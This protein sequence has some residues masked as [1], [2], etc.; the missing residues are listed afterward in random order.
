MGKGRNTTVVGIRLP[1]ET[2]NRLKAV[3]RKN[4]LTMT[5]LLRPVIEDYAISG[6]GGNNV[7]K[8]LSI[9]NPS[10]RIPPVEESSAIPWDETEQFLGLGKSPDYRKSPA[11]KPEVKYRVD[12]SVALAHGL[13]EKPR[14]NQP[15]PCGA[16]HP[17]GRPKKYK[18]CCGKNG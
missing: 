15:C 6:R 18:H 9:G 13:A 10:K 11:T 1:D 5:E 17:D 14:P 12:T 3:A 4:R 2:V 7:G 16:L 8:G